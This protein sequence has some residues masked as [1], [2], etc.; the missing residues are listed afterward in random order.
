MTN[1]WLWAVLVAAG[2]G[3]AACGDDDNGGGGA[4]A[5]GPTGCTTTAAATVF[6]HEDVHPI[7][8]AKCTPCHGDAATTLPKFGSA[9]R[10]TS[11]TAAHAAV[12]TTTPSQ[13]LLI[14]KGDAQVTH[15]GG[16]QLDP[17]QVT[18][19]TKWVQECAL[20]NSRLDPTTP[21][22]TVR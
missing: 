13:S 8:V 19:I 14:R 18:T 4:A 2:L 1:R 17:A 16:D 9:D 7:L 6:F 12:N 5:P 11:Y 3:L 10:T 22:T 15:G 21:T 20:N